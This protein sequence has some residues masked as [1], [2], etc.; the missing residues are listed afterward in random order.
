M[1]E[2]ITKDQWTVR[3]GSIYQP[4]DPNLAGNVP[5]SKSRAEIVAAE[6]SER[7]EDDGL[8]SPVQQ[9][10]SS[11]PDW[12]DITRAQALVVTS[13]MGLAEKISDII[14]SL[15][16]PQ[17]TYAKVGWEESSSFSF[18]GVFV[19]QLFPLLDVSP[20]QQEAMFKAAKAIKF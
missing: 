5:M 13:Q 3:V 11:R 7:L 6:I 17:R 19:S 15:P 14:A 2:E 1:I 4:F 18:D 9:Q 12:Y 20:A 8:S 16:E 10:R